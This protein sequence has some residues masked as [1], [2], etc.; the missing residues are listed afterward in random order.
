MTEPLESVRYLRGLRWQGVRQRGS[1]V[2][3]FAV[4]GPLITL[5]G[6]TV[7]QYALMFNAK[8]MVNHAGFMAAREG[9]VAHGNLSS[10]Q[11]AYARALIPLYG[12]GTDA[13][14]L[15]ASFSKAAADVASHSRIELL[16][17]TPESFDDWA[18][19]SLRDRYGGTR[20]LNHSTVQWADSTVG[21][22]SGQ[23]R[24]DANLIK[25]RITHG[26]EL[27]VPL[28][29]TVMQFMMRWNDR[30]TDSFMSELY[31]DGRV[32]LVTH[33]T[34]A[35]QSDALEQSSN[36]LMP[37]PGNGGELSGPSTEPRGEPPVCLTVGCTV[38]YLPG[39]GTG[40]VGE[41]TGGSGAG[42]GRDLYGC[43]P[44]DPTCT[45]ICTGV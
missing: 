6:T 20:V 29:G 10:I 13:N 18:D 8:N 39:G 37:A 24:R 7:L 45:L 38:I 40:A 4:V 25:L 44:G 22:A 21:T 36:V 15:A 41:A 17:P 27:K 30:G 31:K 33:V 35:M 11:Q 12:G 16:N 19:A 14:S 5:L 23:H 43:S 32:P 3:E 2:V 34:L 1:T 26:Y 42:G 9:S 28:A